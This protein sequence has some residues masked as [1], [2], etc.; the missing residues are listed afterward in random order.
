M[1]AEESPEE[2]DERLRRE[3]EAHA[4]AA[5]IVYGGV[6]AEACETFA[7]LSRDDSRFSLEA[8]TLTGT[9]AETG[10]LPADCSRSELD[11]H[12]DKLSALVL[13]TSLLV[14]YGAAKAESWW[15]ERRGGTSEVT[16]DADEFRS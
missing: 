9:A 7:E 14:G 13:G 10:Y 16:D 4:D 1:E 6:R 11:Y 15:S 2:L 3:R 5:E 12:M 8:P